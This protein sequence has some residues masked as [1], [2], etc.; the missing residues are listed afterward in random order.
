MP[1]FVYTARDNAGTAVTG[2]LV[3]D[4]IHEVTQLLRRDGKYPTSV[5]P[6]EGSG[7]ATG[8]AHPGIRIPRA[9]VIQ[10][11]TQLA[12]MLETGVTLLEALDCFAAQSAKSNVRKLVEDLSTQVQGGNDFSSALARHPKSFPRLYVAMI[13]ASERSGMMSRMMHRATAYLRDEQETLRRVK[14]ALTY[15]GIMLAFAVTTTL[16]LLT[17]VLPRF[18]AI[19]ANKKAALPLPTKV[20]MNASDFVVGHWQVLLMTALTV[21]AGLYVYLC[22]ASGARLWHYVQLNVPLIG[23]MYRKLHLARGMRMIGTMGGAGVSLVDCVSTAHDLCGNSYFREL[24]DEVSRKIQTGK[25]LSDPLFNS[26]LV[27]RSIA[28][29]IHSGE[30]SGKLSQVM[31]QVAA[32]SEQ[33]L[34]EKIVDLTRYIEPAMIVVM[35]AIIGGVALALMMPIFTISRVVAQ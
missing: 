23:A 28:Q 16:F 35:G 34:K 20:L 27:P 25:Q 14:G 32:Y 18:T 29:M 2:T 8:S 12:I 3:A 11:S 31:E 24:W 4:S 15:P 10:L 13:K 19:Y 17:F 30:K 7:P 26:P 33:E 21:G 5:K 22:T 1:T 6:A 9:D